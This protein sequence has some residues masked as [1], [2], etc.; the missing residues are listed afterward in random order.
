VGNP[1]TSDPV[2]IS[3]YPLLP[4]SITIIADPPGAVCSGT[5]VTFTAF[6]VNGG[7]LPAYQWKVNSV[8]AGTNDPV[9]TYVPADNDKVAC[10]LTSNDLCTTGNPATSNMI[11]MGVYPPETVSVSVSSVPSGA[12][13]SGTTVTFTAVPV[14]GGSSPFYQWNVNSMNQGINNPV[15]SYIPVDGDSVQCILTSSDTICVSNNPAVSDPVLMIVNSLLPVDISI[16]CS[17]NPCCEGDTIVF[18]ATTENPGTSPFFQWFVNGVPNGLNDSV[19][20]CPPVHGDLITCSLLSNATC[21][22]GNPAVS[23]TIT[24]AVYP[25]L[26]VGVTLVPSPHPVC[27]GFA[28]TFTATPTNGGSN[29]SYQWHVNGTY[30]G[31]NSPVF[32]YIPNYNDS[33]S[34]TL[35]SSELCTSNNP[36]SSIQYPVSVSPAPPV[37]F[38]PCFDTVTTTNAKPIKLKGGIPPGGTYSGPGVSNGYFYPNLA[39]T[40][41]KTIT[42]SYTNYALCSASAQSLIHSFTHSLIP[43]GQP[44]TDIRDGKTYQTVQ[45]GSQCWMAANLNYGTMIPVNTHQRDNCIPEKYLQPPPSLPQPGE[46]SVYQ[47]DELMDYSDTEKAQGLC[48]PG[49]HVPSESDWETLFANWTNNAFA[50]APLKYTGYSGFNAFL[51]G[52]VFFNR[53]WYL[54][55]FATLFWSSTSHGPFKAWAHGMNEYNYSVSYYPS[56]RSNAFTVRCTQD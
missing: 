42:Y 46:G 3:V 8:N 12:V 26:S 43:C 50:G 41:T 27:E 19:F 51:N 37:T 17:A 31:T 4:V 33:V 16:N 2:I 29:P 48:P 28:V 49:W 45:I 39:G 34:C 1:A 38:S 30:T 55:E 14:N 18:T 23:D 54:Q 32:T 25:L 7:T 20:F 53:N 6:P 5:P 13:C 40:G 36:A 15:F 21:A 10:I 44:I 9:F 35:M 22:T 52:A 11:E 47:W 56:N 24:M